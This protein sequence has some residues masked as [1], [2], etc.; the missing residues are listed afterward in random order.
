MFLRWLALVAMVS[1]LYAQPI[2]K[3]HH[4][5]E[6]L[7]HRV[8]T[9]E[10]ILPIIEETEKLKGLVEELE[11]ES[12]H[13]VEDQLTQLSRTI[14]GHFQNDY[15]LDDDEEDDDYYDDDY[16]EDV[17]RDYNNGMSLNSPTVDSIGFD[18][19]DPRLAM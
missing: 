9:L 5:R 15:S 14:N 7:I 11:R 8:Q 12:D 6:E 18:P 10:K 4:T 13:E 2:Q 17:E 1:I 19:L 16:E 3:S